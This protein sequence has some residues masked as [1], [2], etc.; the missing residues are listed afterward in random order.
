MKQLARFRQPDSN[1]EETH[2]YA[3]ETN[4][5]YIARTVCVGDRQIRLC[6]GP[7]MWSAL[8]E[9]RAREGMTLTALMNEI[10]RAHPD[11]SIESALGIYSLLYFMHAAT[12][13]GHR[14][15]GHGSLSGDYAISDNSGPWFFSLLPAT[16]GPVS[17]E[18]EAARD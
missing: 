17:S 18:D 12:E 8:K 7:K 16:A 4:G 3:G 9:I 10:A 14:R 6:M 15:A 11:L 1:A 5:S 2:R 13:E